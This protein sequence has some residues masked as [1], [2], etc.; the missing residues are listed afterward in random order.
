M[1]PKTDGWYEGTTL[2]M[3]E[4]YSDEDALDMAEFEE[5]MSRAAEYDVEE[6][7]LKNTVVHYQDECVQ[8]TARVDDNPHRRTTPTLDRSHSPWQGC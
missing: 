5:L 7:G 6:L 2:V 3:Q 4:T 1:M 8:V